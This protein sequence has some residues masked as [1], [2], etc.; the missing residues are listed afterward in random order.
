MKKGIVG[1]SLLV[2]ALGMAGNA[3]AY[4]TV[5]FVSSAGGYNNYSLTDTGNTFCFPSNPF[6][7]QTCEQ[8]STQGVCSNSAPAGSTKGTMSIRIPYS[9]SL[10]DR[11]ETYSNFHWSGGSNNLLGTWH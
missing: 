6:N 7:N 10:Y 3:H 5:K 9:C 1:A 4:V 8:L 2:A 11:T